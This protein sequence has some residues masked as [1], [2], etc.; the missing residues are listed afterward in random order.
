M[1]EIWTWDF[2]G[3]FQHENSLEF[4]N[5]HQFYFKNFLSL[6]SKS[7]LIFSFRDCFHAVNGLW[8]RLTL[9]GRGA[10]SFGPNDLGFFSWWSWTCPLSPPSS[11]WGFISFDP[12]YRVI[13]TD[14]SNLC[15]D[16]CIKTI[17]SLCRILWYV[18]LYA[19]SH[20]FRKHRSATLRDSILSR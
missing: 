12:P 20:C 15:S 14:C 18:K 10:S 4:K 8:K 19:L 6:W 13:I 16:Y 7:G 11:L 17:S 2:R 1:G 5:W 3:R 9:R